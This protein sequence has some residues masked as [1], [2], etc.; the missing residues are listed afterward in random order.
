LCRVEDFES[1]FNCGDG[2]VSNGSGSVLGIGAAG[3]GLG[4]SIGW[5][6]GFGWLLACRDETLEKHQWSL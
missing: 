5:I 3:I 1:F 6:F 2:H 4:D